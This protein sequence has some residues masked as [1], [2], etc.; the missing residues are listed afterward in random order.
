MKKLLLLSALF[1]SCLAKGQI[2]LEHTYDSASTYTFGSPLTFSE[3]MII[4]FEVSGEHYVKINKWGKVIDIYDMNHSLT[5]TISLSSLPPSYNG[6]PLA[7][8]LYLSENLFNTDSKIEFMYT[9]GGPPPNTFTGIYN[10]N[11]TLLFSD[12]GAAIV[13][14]NWEMQ[15]F[16]IYNTSFGT[17]MILSY[18]GSSMNNFKAKVF[19]LP[20]TLSTGIENGNKQLMQNNLISNP[21]PNPNR[22]YTNIDYQLPDGETTGEIIFYDLAG[23]EVKRFRVDRT[24]TSLHLSTADLAPG[25]YY[26]QLQTSKQSS[27]GKKMVVIK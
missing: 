16:P 17:K 23:N 22:N 6:G 8:I 18:A 26:Y 27:Q 15:Q 7:D 5:K 24:F 21:Y 9:V 1:V 20:G 11:G 4:K 2:T 13:H 12:T 14:P 25:T 3:L 19:S 10:E